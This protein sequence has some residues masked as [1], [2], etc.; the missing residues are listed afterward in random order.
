MNRATVSFVIWRGPDRAISLTLI[1]FLAEI[2]FQPSGLS[3][4][5]GGETA[6]MWGKR[7]GAETRNSKSKGKE[8][9]TTCEIGAGS[10]HVKSF[11]CVQPQCNACAIDLLNRMCSCAHVLVPRTYAHWYVA[12]YVTY[13]FIYSWWYRC[14]YTRSKSKLIR[15]LNAI[16]YSINI[17]GEYSM[18]IVQK[19]TRSERFVFEWRNLFYFF[20]KFFLP[21]I[22]SCVY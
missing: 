19:I 2:S 7:H 15:G 3:T 21:R 1:E 18:N 20:R 10:V 9:P 22:S 14:I 12:T 8:M 16:S 4:W 5:E 11:Y 6:V 13:L 17:R